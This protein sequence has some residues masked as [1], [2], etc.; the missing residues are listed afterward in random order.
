MGKE[1]IKD[2]FE[3]RSE[4]KMNEYVA[5]HFM[6]AITKYSKEIFDKSL[7]ITL[8]RNEIYPFETPEDFVKYLYGVCRNMK[9]AISWEE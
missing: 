1:T 7:E 8:D 3:R 5:A 4:R 2:Y 9:C 6:N